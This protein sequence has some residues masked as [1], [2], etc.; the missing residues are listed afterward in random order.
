LPVSQAEHEGPDIGTEDDDDAVD[1][2][3]GG[4][5]AEEEQPEPD[6]DVDLLVH[7]AHNQAKVTVIEP[8]EPQDPLEPHI[9][10]DR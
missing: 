6:E 7:Y 4:E 2:D 10:T 3:N 1:D 5:E 9:S 8:K